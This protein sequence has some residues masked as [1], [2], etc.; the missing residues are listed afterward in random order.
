MKEIPV[1]VIDL[2][3]ASAVNP[4]CF[5][6]KEV[7][8]AERVIEKKGKKERKKNDSRITK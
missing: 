2:L 4:R 8:A 1:L 5:S 7:R 3:C 6:E